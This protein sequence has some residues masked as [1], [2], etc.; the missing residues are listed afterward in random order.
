[1]LK[2]FIQLFAEKFLFNK[3]EWVCKQS[4]PSKTAFTEI[5]W[6]GTS[7]QDFV[8]PRD[9]TLC[10][11]TQGCSWTRVF[12]QT[13]LSRCVLQ[14]NDGEYKAFTFQAS[15]GETIHINITSAQTKIVSI[16][17]IPSIGS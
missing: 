8:P 15:K 1:M 4:F 9:G 5:T 17:F 6:N 14:N 3:K 10:I 16:W 7:D 12:S 2:A 13:N 11:T